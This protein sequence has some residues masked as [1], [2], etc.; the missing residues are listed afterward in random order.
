IVMENGFGKRTLLKEYRLQRRGG[1]GIK[2]AKITE[3]TGKLVAVKVLSQNTKEVLIIS[4]KGILI[5]TDLT[6]ISRQSRVSQGVKII[7]LDDDD[8]VAGVVVL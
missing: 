8:L 3:K 5:K 4:K 7:R 6:N 1:Q 2:V